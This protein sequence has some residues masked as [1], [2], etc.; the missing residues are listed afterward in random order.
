MDVVFSRFGRLHLDNNVNFWEIKSPSGDICGNNAVDLPIFELPE[1]FLSIELLDVTMKDL[2]FQSD[3]RRTPYSIDFSLSLTEYYNF[4]FVPLQEMVDGRPHIHLLFSGT[5]HKAVM[6]HSWRR[7]HVFVFDQIN[8]GSI[9]GL[10]TLRNR[11][12]PLWDGCREEKVLSFLFFEV[13]VLEYFLN[14]LFEP[15]LQHLIC[16]IQTSGL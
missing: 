16:L 7:S 6:L 8:K 10:I 13:N 12:N 2:F 11:P 3:H 9:F 5:R 14:V 4:S 15:L 1:G